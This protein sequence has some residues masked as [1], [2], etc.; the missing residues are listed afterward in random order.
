MSLRMRAGRALLASAAAI[1]AVTGQAG[2]GQ[3]TG[4]LGVSVQV[5]DTCMVRSLKDLPKSLRITCGRERATLKAD[6]RRDEAA[7]VGDK[8]AARAVVETVADVSYL[9]VIY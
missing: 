2:A 4:T 1:V 7:A 5:V 6:A 8:I 9:T 3:V